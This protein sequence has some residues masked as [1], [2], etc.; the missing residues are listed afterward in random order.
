MTS[1]V[2]VGGMAVESE[3]SH[4]H[5]VTFCCCVTDGNRGADWQNVVWHGNAYKTKVYHWI[6]SCEK[7]CTHWFSLMLAE[8]L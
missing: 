8:H 5:S 2:G 4:Q 3:P 1:E 7:I 6:Y